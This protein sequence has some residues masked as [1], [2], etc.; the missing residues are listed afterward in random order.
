MECNTFDRQSVRSL[1]CEGSRILMRLN[2]PP[3]DLWWP[4]GA[5]AQQLYDLSVSINP[6]GD[7]VTKK[8]GFR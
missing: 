8:V 7:T 1:S 6:D 3:V 2:I 5:G 4:N